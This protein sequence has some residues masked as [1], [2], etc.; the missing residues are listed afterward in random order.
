MNK[1]GIAKTI[2]LNIFAVLIIIAAVRYRWGKKSNVNEIDRKDELGE[3][4]E[5]DSENDDSDVLIGKTDKADHM[6]LFGSSLS[7]RHN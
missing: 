7:D 6:S 2:I 1:Y 5:V 3:L 4:F